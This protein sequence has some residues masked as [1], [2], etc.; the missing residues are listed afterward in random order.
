MDI[1]MTKS[2]HVLDIKDSDYVGWIRNNYL[3][4]P[5]KFH[6]KT[7][8]GTKI[9]NLI[10]DSF[11]RHIVDQLKT[12]DSSLTA[13]DLQN[14]LLDNNFLQSGNFQLGWNVWIFGN[15][16]FKK[17]VK[18]R[19]YRSN[20]IRHIALV[21]FLVGLWIG[22]K[23]PHYNDSYSPIRTVDKPNFK[24]NID[25]WK[26]SSGKLIGIKIIN[27]CGNFAYYHL[28]FNRINRYRN[29]VSRL[30]DY[31]KLSLRLLS[32]QISGIELGNQHSY[33]HGC[34]INYYSE[35]S[36]TTIVANSKANSTTLTK[37]VRQSVKTAKADRPPKLSP[38]AI[39]VDTGTSVGG[40][41]VL[42][43]DIED[44]DN[45]SMEEEIDHLDSTI[46]AVT[47]VW[48][49]L[50][51]TRARIQL[52]LQRNSQSLGGADT[53]QAH[54]LAMIQS[55]EAELINTIRDL[56]EEA[57]EIAAEEHFE[58]LD[59]HLRNDV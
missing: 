45:E 27:E 28:D 59:T 16:K 55:T 15:I 56:R 1:R 13:R 37:T 46:A 49:S 43:V 32:N 54:E 21:K 7:T 58:L 3:N 48:I 20:K 40:Y 8:G 25:N 26:Q 22:H 4:T 18:T 19:Q 47:P 53:T 36:L 52:I 42:D 41:D 10:F 34:C 6:W 2:H 39:D 12:G 24:Y 17:K 29:L 30:P 5:V 11:D 51:G 57:R 31:Y 23:Y 9:R 33:I 44:D 35:C 50:E 14:N 38:Q